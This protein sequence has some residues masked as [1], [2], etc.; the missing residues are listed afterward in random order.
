[1]SERERSQEEIERENNSVMDKLRRQRSRQEAQFDALE[2][3]IKE[4]KDFLNKWTGREQPD[5]NLIN[6]IK[7]KNDGFSSS[8]GADITGFEDRYWER[9]ED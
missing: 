9:E 6:F 7:G 5:L 8:E 4:T 2:A 1:M 3:Q